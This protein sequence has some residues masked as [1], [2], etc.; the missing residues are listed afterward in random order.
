MLAALRQPLE[1]KLVEDHPLFGLPGPILIAGAA[2]VGAA[3]AA[4]VAIWR[5]RV[6]LAHDRK[7]RSQEHRRD[8]LDA[9]IETVDE[10][11]R[12][13]T[14]MTGRVQQAPGL[15][16]GPLAILQNPDSSATAKEEAEGEIDE[17]HDACKE[18][19]KQ[20]RER[21]IE[22]TVQVVRLN[23]RFGEHE[24]SNCYDALC[25]AFSRQV[26]VAESEVENPLTDEQM[27]ELTEA[28]DLATECFANLMVACEE[29]L[30]KA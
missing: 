13:V 8:S 23:L 15:R 6:Q 11:F 3:L 19:I 27:R 14:V 29:W 16:E 5:M 18:A 2:I 20:A 4:A 7:M 21:D 30:T 26:D 12:A 9:A 1:V 25:D 22:M 28:E 24:I 17:I 10:T